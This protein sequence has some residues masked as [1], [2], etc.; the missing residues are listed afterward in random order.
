[1]RGESLSHALGTTMERL[2]HENGHEECLLYLKKAYELANDE[3]EPRRAIEALGY[4]WV[5][6]EAL[7]I[8]VYCALKYGDDAQKAMLLAVNHDGDSDST[9]SICGNLLGVWKGLS[10]FPQT[11]IDGIEGSD[12][13]TQ[14][15]TDLN[16]GPVFTDEWKQRYP[17]AG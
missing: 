9:G 17:I 14:A 7:A 3:I 12:I 11:W 10:V 5:G 1:M 4:G 13:L 6:E 8:A 2:K 15:A 16:I